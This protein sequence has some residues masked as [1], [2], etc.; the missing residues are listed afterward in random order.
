M[1]K[2]FLIILLIFTYG[3]TNKSNN[4]VANINYPITNIGELDEEITSYVNKTY[5]KYKKDNLNISYKYKDI[6]ENIINISLTIKINEN[7]KIKTFTYDKKKEKFLT[8]ENIVRDVNTLD[9]NLKEQLLEKY[10]D[11][12][13]EYLNSV[14]LNL[15]E[16][17]DKNLRIF[18]N[19][20]NINKDRE[21]IHLDIPLNSLDLIIDKNDDL[22]LSLKKKNISLGDKI[23]A[24]TFDDG[25]S[26]YTNDI[27]DILK[28]YK[29]SATFFVVGEKAY[30]GGE[31]LKRIL[32][33]GSEIGNHSFSHKLLTNLTEEEFKNEINQTQEIIKN[34]TGFTP[35]LFRPTYGGYTNR[36]KEYTNLTFVLW[37]VD[38]KDWKVKDKDKIINNVV[39]YVKSGSIILFHDNHEYAVN[40]IEDILITLKDKG[41]KFVTI[42]ELLEYKKLMEE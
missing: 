33:E 13:I 22:Y 11:I 31:T 4:K 40:S 3:C 19:L 25:P 23:V 9:Y 21:I 39:P 28:K 36:L 34:L 7:Y 30:Y 32:N 14:N 10:K 8:I 29:A 12:N 26:K 37:D 41:Y 5:K 6:N 17:D 38:S 42:S 20:K 24:I 1:W 16:F 18:L 2:K 15:F 35:K 27:L